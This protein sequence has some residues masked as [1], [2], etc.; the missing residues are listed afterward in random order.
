M[1][2]NIREDSRG[3]IP[4]LCNIEICIKCSLFLNQ[5]IFSQGT[6]MP[7]G[8]GQVSFYNSI[9]DTLRQGIP[10]GRKNWIQFTVSGFPLQD[11][12]EELRNCCECLQ[13][14]IKL[15]SRSLHLTSRLQ[16]SAVSKDTTFALQM[17]S[18]PTFSTLT[19]TYIFTS[20]AVFSSWKQERRRS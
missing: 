11:C 7:P 18:M 13:H 14:S 8:P 12:L 4:P 9:W 19:H 3:S 10:L 6:K 16:N 17:Q 15:L 5:C 1:L 2:K 20:W